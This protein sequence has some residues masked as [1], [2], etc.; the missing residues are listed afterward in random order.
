MSDSARSLEP[1]ARP[2]AGWRQFLA[3]LGRE[4][5]V[6]GLIGF[7]FAATGP[8]AVILSVGV[9]GGLS[10]ERLASWIFGVFFLNSLLTIAFSL[11][12]RRP[13]AFFWTIPG[14]VLVGPALGHLA[15]SDI[16]GA[17][18]ATGLLMLVLGLTGWVKRIMQAIPMSIVM[19]MVAGSL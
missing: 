15:F 19:A 6:N 2:I 11:L 16:V 4:P 7:I 9:G 14:T 12:Y 5:A 1:F 3:D 17:F 8:V 13:L 10:P 18:I